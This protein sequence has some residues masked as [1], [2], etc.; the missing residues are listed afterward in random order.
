MWDPSLP[1]GGRSH[2]FS[3]LPLF[4][5]LFLRCFPS[6]FLEVYLSW[7]SLSHWLLMAIAGSLVPSLCFYSVRRLNIGF[8]GGQ[9]NI[10]STSMSRPLPIPPPSIKMLK[11]NVLI[12]QFFYYFFL[13]LYQAIVGEVFLPLAPKDVC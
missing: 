9:R 12:K 2:N 7:T 13:F 6:F 11:G 10:S 4:S 8:P 1:Y 5:L 3:P